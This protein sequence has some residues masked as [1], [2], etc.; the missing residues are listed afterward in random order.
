LVFLTGSRE[1]NGSTSQISGIYDLT[2]DGATLFL[3]AV[4]YMAKP[5]AAAPSFTSVK[6]GT[7]GRITVTWTGGG[8]LQAAPTPTGPWTDVAG[9]TSPYVLNP[10]GSALFGRI[11]L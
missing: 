6:L 10:T 8:T 9:A 4:K 1:A 5:V 11:K 7:D 3:N 2:E